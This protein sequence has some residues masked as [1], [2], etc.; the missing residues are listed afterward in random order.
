MVG[1][2]AARTASEGRVLGGRYELRAEIARG[3]TAEIWRAWDRR[4]EREVAIKLLPIGDTARAER[5]LREARAVAAVRH[6][7]VVEVLDA[8]QEG[9]LA[10]VVFELL[11]GEPLH[12]SL[13]KG[14]MPL[15]MTVHLASQVLGGLVAVHDAGIAHRD[16]KP[17]N[18]ILVTDADGAYPKIVDFGISKA[19]GGAKPHL[20]PV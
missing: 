10:Y 7:H 11:E 20:R 5:F 8:G 2:G 9:E 18:I 19:T 4:L 6:R 17:E 3:G 12:G 16:L 1:K 14:P 15:P 13:G